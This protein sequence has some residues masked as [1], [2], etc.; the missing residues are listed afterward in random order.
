MIKKKKI[1]LENKKWKIWI[2]QNKDI[3]EDIYNTLKLEDG[4]EYKKSFFYLIEK[5]DIISYEDIQNKNLEDFIKNNNYSIY[6]FD[7]KVDLPQDYKN[8]KINQDSTLD[9]YTP[10]MYLND[11]EEIKTENLTKEELEKIDKK[12]EKLPN[13]VKRFILDREAYTW[14]RYYVFKHKWNIK[15]AIWFYGWSEWRWNDSCFK[16]YFSWIENHIKIKVSDL[17]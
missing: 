11:S 9:S 14:V 2:I 12:I 10:E 13:M 5:G 16:D 7:L 3:S 8:F 6:Y 4:L 1:N 17:I 15:Y